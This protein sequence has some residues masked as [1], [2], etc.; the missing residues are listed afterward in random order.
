MK[1]IILA[2]AVLVAFSAHADRE[3]EAYIL[4]EIDGNGEAASTLKSFQ[5]KDCVL[6]AGNS[7]H[8]SIFVR[9]ARRCECP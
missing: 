2:L 3:I 6:I 5:K 9:S 1:T 7:V 4:G 8:N